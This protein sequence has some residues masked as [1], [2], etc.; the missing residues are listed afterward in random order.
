[1]TRSPAPRFC[2]AGGDGAIGAALRARLQAR[3]IETI[4]SSRRAD[5]RE[6]F[7]L[8]LRNPDFGT[9]LCAGDVVVLA[10]AMTSLAA[11]REDPFA[12]RQA[13][14]DAPL[15]LARQARDAGAF[16]VFPSTNQVFDGAILDP[17]PDA[18][19]TPRSIYG[20]LKAEAE[21]RLVELGSGVAI[22]RLGKAIGPH[23]GLFGA[24]RGDLS[25]GRPIKAFSDLIM[26][27]IAMVKIACALERIGAA[28]AAGFWHL[29]GG[30][31]ID[32]ASAARHVAARLGADAGLVIPALAAEA[33]IPDEERPPHVRLAPGDI[34][35][36]VGFSG[37]DA[38]S[39]LDIGLGFAAWNGDDAGI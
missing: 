35:R 22:L 23:L 6:A 11:C 2:I 24:W 16:L 25:A 13:N 15:A 31:E 8:D 36:I 37:A 39:E 20:K 38:R 27:P 33:G 12:A 14:V 19:T 7:H 9:R 1:V 21:A 30:E 10:A 18:P 34:A 3:G 26:A 17:A 4:W 29:S 28:R 5:T 32:Y